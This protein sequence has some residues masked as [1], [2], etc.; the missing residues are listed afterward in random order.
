MGNPDRFGVLFGLFM[1][2]GVLGVVSVRNISANLVMDDFE[3]LKVQGQFEIGLNSIGYL[4]K[5]V[6]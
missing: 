4:V 2:I 3:L 6:A 1:T 5:E